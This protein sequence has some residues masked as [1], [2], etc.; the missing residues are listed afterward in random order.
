M[1][2]DRSFDMDGVRLVTRA[3]RKIL[4]GQPVTTTYLS[5]LSNNIER[6]REMKS[7]WNFSCDCE[8]CSDPTECGSFLST[9]IC[10]SCNSLTLN[11]HP[12][13]SGSENNDHDYNWICSNKNCEN[14][15][16]DTSEIRSH[17][18]H[19][20]WLV[21]NAQPDISDVKG[22][23]NWLEMYDNG[24]FLHSNHSIF[25]QVKLHLCQKYG[26]GG[27]MSSL[28]EE[29]L[30]QKL[31]FCK[32]VT[33][34]LDKILR[35]SYLLKGVVL[36]ELWLALQEMR[37]RRSRTKETPDTTDTSP[38]DDF[39]HDIA[40]KAKDFLRFCPRSSAEELMFNILQEENN[41]RPSQECET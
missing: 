12:T 7:V 25:L 30:N 3:A 5:H 37:I 11:P 35:G 22:T 24:K 29:E 8:R 19:T 15:M 36:F 33:E 1:N 17:L 9:I 40:N 28:S 31:T 23:E 4:K 38:D 16:T 14:N 20:V 13:N 39:I 34:V 21:E 41:E 2:T 27:G 18:H 32:E 6:Q 10:P 26:S